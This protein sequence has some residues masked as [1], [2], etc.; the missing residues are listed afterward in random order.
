MEDDE[1]ETWIL[2]MSGEA[3]LRARAFV[4]ECEERG[5]HEYDEAQFRLEAS[6][7]LEDVLLWA[8]VWEYV[9]VRTYAGWNDRVLIEL[10]L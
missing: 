1:I 2:Q 5:L 10:R 8:Q 9:Q 7:T 4:R 3:L 6:E